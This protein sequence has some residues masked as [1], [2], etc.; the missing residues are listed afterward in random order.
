MVNRKLAKDEVDLIEFFQIIWVKKHIIIISIIFGLL[1]VFLIQS[2]KKPSKIVSRTKVIPISIYVSSEFQMYNSVLKNLEAKFFPPDYMQSNENFES[3]DEEG[4]IEFKRKQRKNIENVEINN[5]TKQILFEMFIEIFEQRVILRNIIKKFN[6]IK[7]EDYTN[8]EAY[9]IAIDKTLSEIRLLNTND[10]ASQTEFKS[11]VIIELES[12]NVDEWESFLIF[13]E[14]EINQRV[15]IKLSKM[16]EKYLDYVKMLERFSLED[17]ESRLT[18]VTDDNEKL[19]IIKSIDQLKNSNYSQ[20]LVELYNSSP[21]SKKDKFIAAK[22]SI[23]TAT[24]ELNTD[25]NSL[26][27]LYSLSAILGGILGIF[28]VVIANGLQKRSKKIIS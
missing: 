8:K 22:I 23:D 3:R 9:E 4:A 2:F 15:Q 19:Y 28:F 21:I 16:F 12:Y 11:N 20:R 5:I 24:Y 18:M 14:K 1:I 7:K 27:T 26:K 6:F 10:L 17:L 25:K 13:V